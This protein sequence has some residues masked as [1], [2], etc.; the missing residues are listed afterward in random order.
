MNHF[1]YADEIES[2]MFLCTKYNEHLRYC[3]NVSGTNGADYHVCFPHEIIPYIY[4]HVHNKQANKG[5]IFQ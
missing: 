2:L 3:V 4:S 5:E 1:S